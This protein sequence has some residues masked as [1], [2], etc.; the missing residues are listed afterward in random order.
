MGSKNKSKKQSKMERLEQEEYDAFLES[1]IK[2][3]QDIEDFDDW[4]KLRDKVV[5][6]EV[7]KQRED[8]PK[9]AIFKRPTEPLLPSRSYIRKSD[10]KETNTKA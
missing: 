6:Q 1:S 10:K 2:H 5:E 9:Y 7:Q 3:K 4:T 8:D